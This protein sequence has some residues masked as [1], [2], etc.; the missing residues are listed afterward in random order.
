M[1]AL[2]NNK[3]LVRISFKEKDFAENFIQ[4]GIQ[5]AINNDPGIIYSNYKLYKRSYFA[6][7]V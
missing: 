4:Q 3:V 2:E 7:I 6:S 1:F 5:R